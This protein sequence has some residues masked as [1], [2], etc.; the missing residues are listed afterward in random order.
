MSVAELIQDEK[1]RRSDHVGIRAGPRSLACLSKYL[2][3]VL[4]DIGI[5]A[6]RNSFINFS[7]VRREDMENPLE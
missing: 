1:V 6:A 7:A 5:L 2:Q 3:D 4:L